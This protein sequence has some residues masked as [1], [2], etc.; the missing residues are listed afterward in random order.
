M[1]GMFEEP[2]TPIN[3]KLPVIVV[4]RARGVR[5]E[6]KCD[7]LKSARAY[8]IRVIGGDDRMEVRL[9]DAKTKEKRGKIA[10]FGGQ[11]YWTF[12]ENTWSITPQGELLRDWFDYA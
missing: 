5:K 8:A 1:F 7:N 2:P 6:K 12:G 10:L 4:W 3:V 9:Y 11:P